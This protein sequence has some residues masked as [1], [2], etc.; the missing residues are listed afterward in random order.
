MIHY[1][2]NFAMHEF[3]QTPQIPS[4]LVMLSYTM[5]CNSVEFVQKNKSFSMGEWSTK[6]RKQGMIHV[7]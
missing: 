6:F 7:D 4:P 5:L 2:S 3:L 1:A